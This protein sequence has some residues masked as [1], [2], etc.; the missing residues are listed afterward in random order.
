MAQT[1]I[2]HLSAETDADMLRTAAKLVRG[3]WTRGYNARGENGDPISCTQPEAVRFDVLGAISRAV[4]DGLGGNPEVVLTH[5]FEETVLRLESLLY[6]SL[7]QTF[8][9]WTHVRVLMRPR[10]ALAD[11]NDQSGDQNTVVA[12]LEKAAT[13]A[14]A[15]TT[16][17][18]KNDA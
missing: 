12:I 10:E 16:Q 2:T 13:V 9:N 11:W 15:T 5:L 18:D 1:T 6:Q 14:A 3:G 4:M 8:P 7:S 17:K